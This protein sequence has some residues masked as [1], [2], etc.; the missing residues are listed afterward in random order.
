MAAPTSTRWVIDPHTEAKHAI[1]RRYLQA[2]V[3]ILGRTFQQLNYI[4]GFAG[5][6]RYSNG[7]D[8]SPI[9]ALNVA[10][11]HDQDLQ[12]DLK[13]LFVER[14]EN[15]AAT[16]RTIIEDLPRARNVS[17]QVAQSTFETAVDSFLDSNLVGSGGYANPTFAFIDPFGW[18]GF[19]FRIVRRIM[20]SPHCEVLVTFMYEEINRFIDH[21]DQVANFSCLFGTDE[22]IQIPSHFT[23][24]QRRRALH[25]FYVRQLRQEASV[26]YVRSFEMRNER[27][28]TD[29]FLFFASNN[30][31]GLKRMKEAMW[32]VDDSGAFK[33]SDATDPNQIVLLD[34]DSQL[35]VLR[36][37]I[38][39]RFRNEVA[40]VAQIEEFVVAETPFLATHYKR[41]LRALEV[42]NP[43]RLSVLAAPPGRRVGTFANRKMRLLIS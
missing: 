23:P 32:K 16:L 19:P 25:D 1:L 27:N 26:K 4:D 17:V 3:P 29:Y 24:E 43:P 41:L 33:Y 39:G 37:L 36:N 30:L 31:T 35:G 38:I 20:T 42:E 7:E 11:E 5:P 13:Y 14:D 18:T 2:W 6:G 9:I 34:L 15:R 40:T 12:C 28:A 10:L 21:P 8:G 22:P